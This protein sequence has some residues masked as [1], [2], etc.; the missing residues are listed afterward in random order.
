MVT[1]KAGKMPCSTCNKGK[2]PACLLPP[3]LQC[4]SELHEGVSALPRQTEDE[5]WPN[6]W[7]QGGDMCTCI[8]VHRALQS[9][10]F[11]WEVICLTPAISVYLVIFRIE[12]MKIF[13]WE[14]GSIKGY[15]I[16]D[17]E[18]ICNIL[19]K[20]SL[21][22]CMRRL[23]LGGSP[24]VPLEGVNWPSVLV[25]SMIITSEAM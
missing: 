18:A 23:S 14:E 24:P 8:C 16:R 17:W 10:T 7:V 5:R 15:I 20:L 12:K 25:T 1:Y 4:Q 13:G 22:L 9:V 2:N 11:A 6:P 21:L 19:R 3:F